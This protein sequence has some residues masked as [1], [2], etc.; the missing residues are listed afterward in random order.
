VISQLPVGESARSTIITRRALQRGISIKKERKKWRKGDVP[1][2]RLAHTLHDAVQSLLP[3]LTTLLL[4]CSFI[5]NSSRPVRTCSSAIWRRFSDP[6]SRTVLMMIRM[7]ILAEMEEHT[8]LNAVRAPLALGDLA[9]YRSTL[10][11]QLD[12]PVLGA[13]LEVLE[14]VLKKITRV[15]VRMRM[16]KMEEGLRTCTTRDPVSWHASAA[17]LPLRGLVT[18]SEGGLESA[19]IRRGGATYYAKIGAGGVHESSMIYEGRCQ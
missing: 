2:R 16:R 12:D 1:L 9:E 3:A 19:S 6:C 15:R 11:Q 17:Y 14:G 5:A 4:P 8:V 7:G 13:L 10:F 18:L